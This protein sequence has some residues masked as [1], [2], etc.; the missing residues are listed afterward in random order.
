[1]FAK[2]VLGDGVTAESAQRELHQVAHTG[3]LLT[4]FL[5]LR[6][7]ASGCTALTGVEAIS[8]GVPAFR[9]PKSRNAAL[10]L[11]GMGALATTMFAGITALALL[12]HVHMEEGATQR[13]ALSQVALACFG[14]GPLFYLLQAFTAAIL[15]L[16]ANTAFNGFPVLASILGRDGHLPH[17]LLH[18]GHRLLSSNRVLLLSPRAPLLP[19]RF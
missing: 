3:G 16:A 1:G 17:Q 9:P 15:V 4:V 2:V 10:T 8:N 7:F 13:T 5:A 12:A 6:A 18:R 14:S 11:V 19:L